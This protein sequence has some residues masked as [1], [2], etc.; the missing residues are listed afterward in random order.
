[1][2]IFII[3][4]SFFLASYSYA[5]K[6]QFTKASDSDPKA[7]A[8]LDKLKK[9][10]QSSKA[11][12]ISFDLNIE[13]PGRGKEKQTGKFIQ[14]GKK[15]ALTSTDQEVFCDGKTVWLYIKANKEVQINNFEEGDQNDLMMTPSQM[16][17]MY[18]SGKYVYAITGNEK[19]NGK[20]ATLIEF[21]PLDKN[22]EYSKL[23][24]AVDVK[25]NRVVSMRVFS[26]DGSRFIMMVKNTL[27][28]KNYNAETF[29]FNKSKYPGIRVEDLR[30]D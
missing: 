19:E 16:M 15:F 22:S 2:R 17:R 20:D 26:K 6:N 11:M 1:M 25:S 8:I 3:I 21:K 23:R 10:Y 14:Q 5:Q 27:I 12:E 29:V 28:N 24:L 4:F 18:E 7:K 13:M 9:E 30:I